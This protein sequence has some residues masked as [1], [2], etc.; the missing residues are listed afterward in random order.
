MSDKRTI[1]ELEQQVQKLKTTLAEYQQKEKE[2]L[3]VL[4]VLQL[5]NNSKTIEQ[6]INRL[7]GR[8]K[9]WS[10]CEAVGIRIR[11]GQDFPY[12]T[13]K[14]FPKQF[15]KEANT[16][17]QYDD[18]GTIKRDKDGKPIL[19]GLCGNILRGKFDPSKNFYTEDGC[20]WANSTTQL[21]TTTTDADRQEYS[22]NLCS[23]EGYESVALIPIRTA[24]E[25]FGLIQF[26]D[27]RKGMFSIELITLYRRI[28][29][30]VA[31][32]L[33]R[34]KAEEKINMLSSVVEQSTEGMAI[35]GLAGNLIFINE[36]WGK[37]HGYENH[38]NLIGEN[39]AISHTPEQMK[40]EV[41]PFINK[42]LKIG[43]HSGEVGHK[44]KNGETFPT[45]MTVNVLKDDKD[46][47]YAIVGVA[48]DITEYKRYEQELQQS[49]EKMRLFVEHA[50]AALAMFDRD[51]RYI[52]HSRRWNSVFNLK[53]NNLLGKSH[54]EIFPEMPDELKLL[55]QRAM[56]GEVIKGDDNKFERIDG[57]VQWL[58]GE[59]RPWNLADGSVGGIVILTEDITARKQVEEKL[60]QNLREKEVLLRELYHRTKNNM[61]VISSI[62]R[63][64]SR[65]L[66]NNKVSVVFKEIEHKIQ[67]MALVH[68]K[69]YESQDLSHLNLKEYIEGLVKLIGKA[70]PSSLEKIEISVNGK[71]INVL[72]D[73]AMAFGLIINELLTNAIKYAFPN[74]R[75]GKIDIT[76]NQNRQKELLLSF[77]DNGVGLPPNFDIRKQSSLG[78]QTIIE[79][80]E[81]QLG[82]IVDFKNG[83]GFS[84]NIV[85]KKE[86]Y[87]PRV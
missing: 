2:D 42:A 75:M 74:N 45:F 32:S 39:M 36:T 57:T 59:I 38:T 46:K 66:N 52:A 7:I 54:Y 65:R 10:N 87:E 15:V 79:L 9:K 76:L 35:V 85:L 16:L 27:H 51:M 4:E 26:N 69:L 80:V 61:Q 77:S 34:L 33:A 68:Q 48:K 37:M 20:F 5:V 60:G 82:G 81:Y 55:H 71:D 22:L 84:C 83:N 53:E 29:D 31:S 43:T 56:N 24:G 25:T 47:P 8:I 28:A 19:K 12:F 11:D 44:K 14:G 21:L 13:T 18:D 64:K 73:T 3:I 30:H 17:Y 86:L 67:S 50:P 72:L 70:Y 58:C 78:I 49:E 23:Q 63:L 62:L 41:K 1:E 40:N 6:L